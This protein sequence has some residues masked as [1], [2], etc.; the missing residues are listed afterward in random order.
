MDVEEWKL[1]SIVVAWKLINQIP[2][3]GK[4]CYFLQFI[5]FGMSYD[6]D[7]YCVCGF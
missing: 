5:M 2:I 3:S 4:M 6:P 7:Y 1:N